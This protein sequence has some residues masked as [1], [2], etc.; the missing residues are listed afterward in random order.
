MLQ[1]KKK[2]LYKTLQKAAILLPSVLLLFSQTLNV[3]ASKAEERAAAQQALPI[4]SNQIEDWPDG[5]IVTAAAAIL[6]EA[7]TGAVLY[8]KTYTNPIIPPAP[9]RF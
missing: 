5:P 1:T 6:M 2:Y 8:A 7:E 3:C 9:P 4:Q